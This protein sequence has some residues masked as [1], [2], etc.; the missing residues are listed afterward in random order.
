MTDPPKDTPPPSLSAK[1]EATWFR[2][3]VVSLTAFFLIAGGLLAWHQWQ[4]RRQHRADALQTMDPAAPDPGVTAAAP[5]NTDA[6][7]KVEVGMYVER[8]PELSTKDATWTGVFDVW[9]RW[10]GDAALKPADGF[11]IMEG[12]I[13]S[14]DK[15]AE[16]HS[17]D[18]HYERYRVTAK[19]STPFPV[20]A[21]PLDEHLI[22]LAIEN[23]SIP[24]DKMLMVPDTESTSVS[25]RVSVPGYKI[26]G[27]SVIEKPHSY[28]TTRGD[29]RLVAGTKSTY[30]QL[31]LGI[32]IKRNGMGLY[33]KMFQALYISVIIALLACFIRPVDL[34][35]RFGLG[36]GALFAA[37][38]NSYLVSSFVPDTGEVALADIVNGIGIVTVLVTLIAST[39]SL[40]LYERLGEVDL[41]R[42]LDRVSFR[43]ILTGFLAANLLLVLPGIF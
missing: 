36:I 23:G 1:Q 7:T 13:E 35:P 12:T 37:V 24:R 28:R 14:Q 9:F 8:I 33:V 32:A 40:H 41:S 31:R 27:W 11:V 26:A 38:A 21:F 15:L 22:T 43:I 16:D 17:G 20:A 39:I 19:I 42:R 18:R 4:T 6:A 29:P 34:D 25:S 3:W 5:S 10:T 2:A 30:S